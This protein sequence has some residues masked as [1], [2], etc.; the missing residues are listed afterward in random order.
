MN[1]E[2]KPCPFCGGEAELEAEREYIPS[3]I[4]GI[5]RYRAYVVC[6][7]CGARVG[8]NGTVGVADKVDNSAIKAWNRRTTDE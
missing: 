8:Q 2:L 7:M 6:R 1:K 4:T 5:Y 3:P